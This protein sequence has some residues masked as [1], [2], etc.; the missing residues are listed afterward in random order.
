MEPQD[1]LEGL[2]G[3]NGLVTSVYPGAR[4]YQASWPESGDESDNR[5]R[6]VF[7]ARVED[8]AVTVLCFWA[9]NDW[10]MG[11]PETTRLPL[12]NAHPIRVDEV[13]VGLD[14]AI[15][16]AAAWHLGTDPTVVTLRTSPVD[17]KPEYVM[18]INDCLVTVSASN[19]HQRVIAQ[20]ISGQ[21]TACIPIDPQTGLVPGTFTDLL[22]KAYPDAEFLV[23][24][25]PTTDA[26]EGIPT[27]WRFTFKAK[28][29]RTPP[30]IPYA[31]SL[32]SFSPGEQKYFT[33]LA[34]TF[35][36]RMA[37]TAGRGGKTAPMG[38]AEQT[39]LQLLTQN[40]LAAAAQTLRTTNAPELFGTTGPPA[41]TKEPAE[42]A[43]RKDKDPEQEQEQ[44]E[45]DEE[46]EQEDE[47][48]DEEEDEEKVPGTV[49]ISWAPGTQTWSDLT[50]LPLTFDAKPFNAS[51]L[52]MEPEEAIRIARHS[53]CYKKPCES[54]RFGLRDD[55]LEDDEVTEEITI[56]TAHGLETHTR[57]RCRH[58]H[59]HCHHHHRA[60]EDDEYE[61][62]NNDG[63][64]HWYRHQSRSRHRRRGYCGRRCPTP[65]PS[66][67]P[68]PGPGPGSSPGREQEPIPEQP[69]Y[70]LQFG[71][72]YAFVNVF[73][74][75]VTLAP[76]EKGA[77]CIYGICGGDD[78]DPF[79]GPAPCPGPGPSLSATRAAGP[80]AH[81]KTPLY[82]SDNERH[83][84]VDDDPFGGPAL[85]P[86]PGPPCALAPAP[87]PFAHRKAPLCDNDDEKQE[88][89]KRGPARGPVPCAPTP[90]PFARKKVPLHGNSDLFPDSAPSPGSAKKKELLYDN[91]NERHE[92][93]EAREDE[94]GWSDAEGD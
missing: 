37:G 89:V 2:K 32:N 73:D 46:E 81:R 14:R 34:R 78:E 76:A 69:Q 54:I 40:F 17:R 60:G 53:T 47:D 4:L 18:R 85:G 15:A 1:L 20:A 57:R 92:L 68:S 43:E 27:L 35:V 10:T 31:E 12:N 6:F 24:D 77:T 63:R 50:S 8:K 79:P 52:T 51:T 30:D 3:A 19:T 23:A 55:Y 25:Y 29:S 62:D 9:D 74:R 66:P 91:D 44:E 41:E 93:L 61:D 36:S 88:L 22:A 58:R 82:D 7:E 84:L 67:G 86:G 33:Q 13:T 70:R 94:R 26:A 49:F 5:W 72:C 64:C 90:G 59:H 71:K 56:L 75:R 80:F 42:Q 48:E 38:R 65:G 45:E 11:D 16:R 87:G 21:G 28:V 83:G 39:F